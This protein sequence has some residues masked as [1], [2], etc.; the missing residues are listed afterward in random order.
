M[1]AE[2]RDR[3]KTNLKVRNLNLMREEIWRDS[4]IPVAWSRWGGELMNLTALSALNCPFLLGSCASVLRTG[5]SCS[6][7]F[8]AT[9]GQGLVEEWM[10]VFNLEFWV[11]ICKKKMQAAVWKVFQLVHLSSILLSPSGFEYVSF[12]DG[13]AWT[14]GGLSFVSPSARA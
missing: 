5:S 3:S 2:I 1:K 9:A 13:S 10:A 14:L 8:S 11:L 4:R 6:L 12:E 7:H